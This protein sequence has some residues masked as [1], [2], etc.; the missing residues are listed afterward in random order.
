MEQSLESQEEL[1]EQLGIRTGQA[2]I[3]SGPNGSETLQDSPSLSDIE[4]AI[5]KVE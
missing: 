1:G 2:L 4:A 3:L 5:A